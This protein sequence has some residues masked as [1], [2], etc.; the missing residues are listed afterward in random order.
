MRGIVHMREAKEEI[1]YGQYD[2]EYVFQVGLQNATPG[3]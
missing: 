1:K 3:G 2:E